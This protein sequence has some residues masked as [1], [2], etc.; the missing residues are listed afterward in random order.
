MNY[1]YTYL[2]ETIFAPRKI[3]LQI[4]IKITKALNLYNKNTNVIEINSTYV[5]VASFLLLIALMYTV[6]CERKYQSLY[7]KCCYNNIYYLGKNN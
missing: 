2:K 5:V 4:K 6:L 7:T 1:I 3:G